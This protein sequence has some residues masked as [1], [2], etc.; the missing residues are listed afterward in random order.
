[1]LKINK[2]NWLNSVPCQ[3][4]M[5]DKWLLVCGGF[6]YGTDTYTQNSEFIC[7]EFISPKGHD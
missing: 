3:A 6:Y 2:K 5:M 7:E 4:A 1:M